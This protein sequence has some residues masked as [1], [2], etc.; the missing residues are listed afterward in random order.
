[1]SATTRATTMAPSAA[2]KPL[3][4]DEFGY[5]QAQHLLNRAG[6]GGTPDQVRL[7]TQWGLEKSVAHL[8]NFRDLPVEAVAPDRFRADIVRDL[9]PEERLAYRKAQQTQDEATVERF[10]RMEQERER[11]DRRQIREV[12]TWWLKRMIETPRPL[13]EKMTLFFHGHFATSYRTIENSYHMFRQ[14]QLFR[15]HAAGNFGELCFQIIRDPAMLAYLDNNE[16]RRERPN[17]NLARELME[18]FTLGEGHGYGERDIKEGAR[19]LTGYTFFGNDFLF[20]PDWHDSGSK[21]I[22]GK[23][24]TFDG[25]GFVRLILG[26]RMCSEYLCLKLY[27][28]FVND[29]P[30]GVTP[31]AQAFVSALARVMR[32]ELYDLAPVLTTLFSSRHFYDALNAGAQIKSPVQL[33]VGAI[34]SLRTPVLDLNILVDAL[35]LMGQ[36]LLFPP[37]VKGWDGGRA[38]INTATLFIR[39]NI[40][41]HLL[42]GLLPTGY[43]GSANRTNFDALALLKGHVEPGPGGTYDLEK[44]IDLLLGLCL[45]RRPLPQRREALLAFAQSRGGAV[46]NELVIALLCL[47]T[48]VP[49]YQLC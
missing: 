38:W 47:I 28:F 20:R 11:Q 7:L 10:R 29:L 25:D 40:L 43:M 39:Q 34:R 33:A 32:D 16:S 45:G 23:R 27:R 12:Q 14:N 22:F 42:T 1:M 31:E 3:P 4:A 21:V 9:A 46:D 2:L 30:G 5:W 36:D 44:T 17:E 35:E 37:S 24:G 41:A 13:E 48:A 6:F 8:V 19:A 15:K 18:L 26:K 49:E